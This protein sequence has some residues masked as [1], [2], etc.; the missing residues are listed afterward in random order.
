M[1]GRLLQTRGTCEHY[2]AYIVFKATSSPDLRGGGKA[3]PG[4]HCM[5]MY[6]CHA[7]I[8]FGMGMDSPDI[9]QTIDWRM[10]SCLEEYVHES[11]RAGRDG[12]RSRAIP[13]Q[14]KGG[15]YMLSY[16]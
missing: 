4:I 8:A 15:K 2:G 10:P 12:N 5:C 6:A 14:E 16:R 1:A 13:C 11:D 3:R 9:R 7:T